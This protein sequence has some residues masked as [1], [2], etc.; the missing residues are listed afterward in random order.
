MQVTGKVPGE[1]HLGR[2]LLPGHESVSAPDLSGG[3][4]PALG[5]EFLLETA[6][7]GGRS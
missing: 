5:A 4:T 7:A 1:G 6:V 3:Q 2:M